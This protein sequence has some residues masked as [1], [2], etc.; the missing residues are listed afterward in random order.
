MC[1]KTLLIESLEKLEYVIENLLESTSNIPNINQLPESADG[2]L[3]LNGICI[4]NGMLHCFG[5][6]VQDNFPVHQPI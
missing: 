1:D 2:M 3:R 5:E 6:Q 4:N